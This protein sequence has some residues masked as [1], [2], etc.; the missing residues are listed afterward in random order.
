VSGE[1]IS[2]EEA[3]QRLQTTIQTLEEG[4]LSLEES[5]QQF[6]TGMKLAH[7]C[8][9]MLDEAELKVSRLLAGKETPEEGVPLISYSSTE[10]PG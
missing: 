10:I 3:F 6:E 9:S 2:F 4:G 7:L 1:Q 5:I 8:G